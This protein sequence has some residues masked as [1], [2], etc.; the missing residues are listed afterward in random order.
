M[1]VLLQGHAQIQPKSYF[2]TTDLGLDAQKDGRGNSFNVYRI[3]ASLNRMVK[4]KWAVGA[5]LTYG[6]GISEIEKSNENISPDMFFYDYYK[7]EISSWN[8]GSQ[9]RYYFPVKQR[10]YVFGEGRIGIMH[11]SADSEYFATSYVKSNP[12]NTTSKFGGSEQFSSLS[13]NGILAPGITYLV[14]DRIGLEMK[15]NLLQYSHIIDSSSAPE[16][17]EYLHKF[18]TVSGF[19]SVRVGASFYF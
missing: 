5:F 14:Y 8:I 7:Q 15:L 3:S 17:T 16:G 19:S 18:S 13:I 12:E 2:A 11:E 9:T 1:F 4:D 6:K 10:L